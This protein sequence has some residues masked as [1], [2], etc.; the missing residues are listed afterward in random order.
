M[1]R[2]PFRFRIV[3]RFEVVQY[4]GV[5]LVEPETYKVI[6]YENWFSRKVKIQ[7]SKLVQNC[8]LWKGTEIYILTILPWLRNK[9]SNQ[10]L[11]LH[12]KLITSH[13]LSNSIK[14]VEEVKDSNV[15]TKPKSFWSKST[16]SQNEDEGATES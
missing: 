1:L 4:F 10:D 11:A 5:Y 8:N 15:I 7:G 13:K 6:L 3:N 14:K 2:N 9:I 12:V 16:G